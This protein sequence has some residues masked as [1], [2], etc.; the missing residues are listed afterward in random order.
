MRHTAAV[1]YW[2]CCLPAEGND[3]ATA[4]GLPKDPVAAAHATL[5]GQP[6]EV[7]LLRAPYERR[8]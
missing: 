6:R 3:F 5:N 7:D 1:F 4:L 2:A 8:L